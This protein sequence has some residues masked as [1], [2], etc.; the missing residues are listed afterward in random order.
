MNKKLHTFRYVI[1]D[2]LSAL[3]T[4]CI[5]FTYRKYTIS[6]FVFD[7]FD[8][9]V[10]Q[11]KNFYIG[12][13]II[14][15]Y[16]LIIYTF[17]GYYRKIYRKSRLKELEQTLIVTFFGT[18]VLF[19][20]II[21]DDMIISYRNYIEYYLFLFS[22]HFLLTY[23]PRFIT[24]T[25]TVRKIHKGIIGFNTVLIGSDEIATE[26]YL[27]AKKQNV[28]SGNKYIGYVFLSPEKPQPIDEFLPCLGSIDD[29]KKIIHEHEIEEVIIA[30]QNGK[31]KYIEQIFSVIEDSNVV[32]K[33]IPQ[34]QDILLGSVKMTSVLQEPLI[35]IYQDLM[36][37]W[38][39]QIKRVL[40]IVLSVI[41]IIIL[42]PV[43]LFLALG[44]IRSSKGPILYKQERIGHRGKPFN[45]YK[46]RSMYLDSEKDGPQL[47]SKE[48]C[49]ITPFGKIM[50]KTRMDELPQFFNVLR[51]DMA[52]VGPR[53]ERQFY[54]DQIVK[55]APHYRLLHRIKPGITSWGQV[56]YGYAENVDQMV[57]R[58]KYDLVYL[59]NMSLQMDI[60]IMI[61]T[62]LIV[63]QGR[64]K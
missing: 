40:D 24:T 6:P 8:E 9:L 56:K 35:Q 60:K 18:L 51:G 22:T 25:S 54:I 12:I 39:K 50:R 31:R 57:E 49:R 32:I 17:S 34:I 42:L 43:Y 37:E 45:I 21:L 41:A 59:E 26:I 16:W 62:T 46:F 11:D 15:I 55:V 29:L 14:P 38:Q 2:Y 48:D 7:Q 10:L 52:L 44:V 13:A 58:L 30:V 4:W 61:H 64:G 53:P 27:R 20:A 47:S 1:F 28:Q 23:I 36:P 3:I 5:F 33:I 19:F 63:L